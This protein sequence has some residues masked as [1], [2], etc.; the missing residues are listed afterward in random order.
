MSTSPDERGM[1][2]EQILSWADQLL[3]R[4]DSLEKPHEVQESIANSLLVIARALTGAETERVLAVDE[5]A[6]LNEGDIE[7]II[8]GAESRED[9]VVALRQGI[10]FVKA[11]HNPIPSPAPSFE[12]P[13]WIQDQFGAYRWVEA[14]L[15]LDKGLRYRLIHD[16]KGRTW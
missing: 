6:S 1:S 4:D 16:P 13:V 15:L 9:L 11:A 3:G 7:E 12:D 10:G 8:A 2:D 5:Q 14:V